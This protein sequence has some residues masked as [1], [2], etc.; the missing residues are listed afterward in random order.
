[1]G[2]VVYVDG[3]FFT[4]AKAVLSPLDRGFTMADGVFD[5]MVGSG[6]SIFRLG[7]HLDRLTHAAKILHIEP[8]NRIALENALIET[9]KMSLFQ[10]HVTRI[11]ITRG[12]DPGR[13]L[14]I[15]PNIKP[16]IVIRTI[17][18][19]GPDNPMPGPRILTISNIPKNH[20]SPIATIK[21]LSYVE[22]II[23]RMEAKLS[24]ADDALILNAQGRVTGSTSSNIFAVRNNSLVTPTM[25]DGALPGIAR[26]TVIEQAKA[27]GIKVEEAPIIVA[28]FPNF[29]EVFLTNVVT[30]IM[31][32]KSLSGTDFSSNGADHPITS[33]VAKSYWDRVRS[34]IHT[35]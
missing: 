2:N 5:T 25:K 9:S 4:E 15:D 11:T 29:H 13:G 16:S 10:Y 3:Q 8:P 21:S 6:D 28:D 12:K 1:M 26:L 23:S 18:W 31:P 22:G 19:H 24:G 30:G 17:Q 33:L 35:C 14:D 27:L 7:D 34:S 20:L 32:V